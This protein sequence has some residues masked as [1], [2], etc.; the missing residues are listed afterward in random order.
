MSRLISDEIQ[1]EERDAVCPEHGAY[2]S[3]RHRCFEHWLP[4][5][6]CDTCAAEAEAKR[7]EEEQAKKRHEAEQ[8]RIARID[9]A[10]KFSQIPYRY[11]NSGF[12]NYRPDCPEA[13]KALA[14]CKSYAER[15]TEVYE[16]GL[17]LIMTGTAGTGKTHLATA[18]MNYL[19]QREEANGRYTTA[20]KLIRAIRS[21][22]NAESNESEN[23]VVNMFSTIPLLIIDE[24]GVKYAS[25]FDRAMLFEIIDN[26]YND[27]LPTILISNLALSALTEVMGERSIDRL[28]EGG[29]VLAFQWD[30]HRGKS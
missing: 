30:S 28:S 10:H 2:T 23:Q 4:W 15:W 26:R 25:D 12:D 3:K 22:Y 27:Q 19:I 8:R 17:N 24:I 18:I 29:S 5:T 21:T 16:R 13:A 14:S 1:I 9:S 7:A 6:G 11:H 20:A